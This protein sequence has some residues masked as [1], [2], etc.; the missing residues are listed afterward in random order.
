[1]LNGR[2][3]N[4]MINRR[5]THLSGQ[6]KVLINW[7]QLYDREIIHLRPSFLTY[8]K[9]LIEKKYTL[10]A[11]GK[12]IGTSA[13]LLYN[14]F[15]YQNQGI[16][17]KL[18]KKILLELKIPLSQ[19]SSYIYAVGRYKSIVNIS[20][21]FII[22]PFFGELLAHSFF[23]GYADDFYL[24]YSNYDLGIRKEFIDIAKNINGIKINAPKN[25]RCD[26]DLPAIV[27]RLLK[28]VFNITS[29]YSK[30]CRISNKFFHIVK[31]NNDFGWYFLKGAF[32]DEGTITGGQIW[33]VRGIENK[34]LAK[35]VSKLAKLLGLKTRIQLTNKYLRAYSV[36]IKESSYELFC[37]KIV[38]ITKYRCKKILKLLDKTERFYRM[39]QREMKVKEDCKKIISYMKTRGEITITDISKVCNVCQSSASARAY[40]LLET[41]NLKLI[42]NGKRV[43]FALN[44]DRLPDRLPSIN[45]IRRSLGWR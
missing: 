32:L 19:V 41:K 35:D 25:F 6:S 9:N 39:K 20:F 10:S 40:L 14:K 8:L 22:E 13:A 29:F 12:L 4:K 1:M 30:K 37:D 2:A 7:Y 34:K 23:D 11:F 44:L 16:T 21:P 38:K 17:V 24:R 36:C 43:S 26:I 27:P 33:V 5:S 45:E 3:Y 31:Q 28:L 42:R 18:L 15:K